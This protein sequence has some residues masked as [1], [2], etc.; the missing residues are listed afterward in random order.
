M[1]EEFDQLDLETEHLQE[2]IETSPPA[3]PVVVIQYRTRGVPWY[4]VLT[5]LILVALGAVA[6]YHRVT[7]RAWRNF[8]P[9]TTASSTSPA[10][11]TGSPAAPAAPLAL[12]SLPMSPGALAEIQNPPTPKA[13]A[14]KTSTPT[15]IA[16]TPEHAKTGGTGQ[17]AKAASPVSAP[18]VPT[19][20]AIP[21]K[22]PDR[23]LASAAP[24]DTTNRAARKPMAV[25]FSVPNADDSPFAEL[26]ISRG[27]PG[28]TVDRQ[29][30]L[31]STSGSET[32]LDPSA[33]AKPAPTEE[34]L[35]MDLEAEAAEKAV[36]LRQ[37][38]D[39]KDRA[40]EVLDS[41]AQAHIEDERAAFRRDLR[42]AIKLAPQEAAD[43]IE[44]LCN[45][46]GRTTSDDLRRRYK[47]YLFRNGGKLSREGKVRATSTVRSSRSCYSGFPCQRASPHGALAKR[48]TKP[49]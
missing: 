2:V 38:R 26:D 14:T 34:Q 42:D 39:L 11:S 15:P 37:R 31:A 22:Q 36:E 28:S 18:S 49:Q 40:R 48:S 46:Y 4:L 7:S 16:P 30:P 10:A 24:R 33:D 20:E 23:Q 43:Q 3:Q 27:Q 12:N 5:L 21:V 19:P 9:P 13:E 25:G 29:P 17:P 45:R 32:E 6:F 1:I 47:T 35:R 8:P 41:E 44:N